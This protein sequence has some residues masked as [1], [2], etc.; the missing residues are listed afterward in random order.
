MRQ[1]APRCGIRVTA[2]RVG[3]SI[4]PHAPLHPANAEPSLMGMPAPSTNWSREQVL[5]LPDDGNRYELVDGELLVSP[6]PRRPHQ[7]VVLELFRRVD[8]YVREHGLGAVYLAPADLDFL[9]GQLLQPDL[10]VA[11]QRP[12]EWADVGI[13]LLVAEVVSPSTARHDRITKRQLYQRAGVAVYWI[14]DLDARVVEVWTPDAERPDIAIQN[15]TWQ[16]DHAVA[17]L[18]VNLPAFFEQVLGTP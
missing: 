11:S 4:V 16:P 2:Q 5:A 14:V 13:P 18:D 1:S 15:L 6:S 7:E 3:G 8:A 9:S 12:S 10:F 17:P